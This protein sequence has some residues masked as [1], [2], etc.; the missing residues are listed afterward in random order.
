MKNG[1]LPNVC[2]FLA[3]VDAFKENARPRQNSARALCMLSCKLKQRMENTAVRKGFMGAVKWDI[4]VNIQLRRWDGKVSLLGGG[5]GHFESSPERV[6]QQWTCVLHQRV[7]CRLLGCMCLGGRILVAVV[8]SMVRL[9]SSQ[10]RR[11][12]LWVTCWWTQIVQGVGETG[13]SEAKVDRSDAVST[14]PGTAGRGGCMPCKVLGGRSMKLGALWRLRSRACWPLTCVLLWLTHWLAIFD[15]EGPNWWC[16][17]VPCQHLFCSQGDYL[18][19]QAIDL[20]S[21]CIQPGKCNNCQCGQQWLWWWWWWWPG[22]GSP[23]T[24]KDV[25]PYYP[26]I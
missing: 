1:G 20:H 11:L 13:H 9:V 6:S 23:V 4:R 21:S 22:G 2:H 12:H 8:V 18:H 15:F 14:T 16:N 5:G 3:G 26:L 25:S 17:C 19:D 24:S 10:K 7:G